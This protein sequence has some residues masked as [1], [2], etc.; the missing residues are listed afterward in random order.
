MRFLL[1]TNILIPLQDSMI[2]LQPNLLNF[3]KLA[4]A[5]GHQLLYHPASERDIQRDSDHQRRER[6]L[7]RLQQYGRLNQV[8]MCPWNVPSTPP[9]DAAD[10]EILYALECDAA[11][12]LVTEDQ[13]VHNQAKQRAWPSA[14]TTSRRPK[15]GCGDFMNRRIY[16]CRTL[17]TLRSIRSR[18]H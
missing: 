8:A 4:Q 9:N 14:F 17:M 1:D 13:G 16:A 11:H 6:T 7:Q 12:A 3:V 10:N 5:N 2:V 15:T 18:L